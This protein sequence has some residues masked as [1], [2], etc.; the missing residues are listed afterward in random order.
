MSLSGKGL[1][2]NSASGWFSIQRFSRCTVSKHFF[3]KKNLRSVTYKKSEDFKY[4]LKFP[5]LYQTQRSVI[6]VRK[7]CRDEGLADVVTL[8]TFLLVSMLITFDIESEFV[9][10]V[11]IRES[12][13]A[14]LTA[15]SH[16]TDNQQGQLKQAT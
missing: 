12:V 14:L 9:G 2:I 6:R 13:A 7:P 16:Q 15:H 1:R 11:L 3:F 5:A 8:L 10:S 4:T